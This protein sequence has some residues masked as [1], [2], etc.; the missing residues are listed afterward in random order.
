MNPRNIYSLPEHIREDDEVFERL[1][2]GKYITI[3]RIVSAGHATPE[4]EWYDQDRD[5]WVVLVRG[6]AL[7]RF[8]D[9]NEVHLKEG[10]YIFIPAHRKH[11]V[12]FTSTHPACMWLAV[13]GDMHEC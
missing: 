4:N 1:A 8:A 9:M 3:E 13:H 2:E 6:D 10:D 12:I 7:I 5:E 11:R